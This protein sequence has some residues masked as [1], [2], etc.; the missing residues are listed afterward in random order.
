MA[1]RRAPWIA[2]ALV[3]LS[4]GAWV[5]RSDPPAGFPPV[6]TWNIENFPREPTQPRR[7]AEAIGALGVPVVAVQ[8][9]RSPARLVGAIHDL[10]G[11]HWAFATH[12][13][14]THRV[15]LL[16]D[17]RRYEVARVR[18]HDEVRVIRGGR[19]ALEVELRPRDGGRPLAFFVVHLKSGP[20]GEAV[21]RA[22]LQALAPIVAAREGPVTV[23]G[24]FNPVSDA[25]RR[26]LDR[27]AIVTG[28]RWN[29]SGLGCT[30]YFPD[31]GRCRG[32]AL[33]HVMSDA[34]GAVAA[35]GACETVGCE[36][37]DQCPTGEVSDHCPV[38]F[39]P[40]R[41]RSPPTEE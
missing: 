24:D 27:F 3:L 35:R 1:R 14:S 31:H 2:V 15:G 39:S 28:L 4:I 20:G 6:A 25:D 41:P 22:Q 19:P 5:A 17:T 8:E 16:V 30:A 29:S 13:G 9:I 36:P 38:V 12:A 18:V 23:L 11:T 10:L 26:D 34:R 7:A 21:R 37:G 32:V 33:D 40:R